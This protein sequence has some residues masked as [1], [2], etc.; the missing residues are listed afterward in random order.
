MSTQRLHVLSG[1]LQH[2]TGS[3]PSRDH[4]E[5]GLDIR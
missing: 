5:H 1:A 3:A 2:S 4:I